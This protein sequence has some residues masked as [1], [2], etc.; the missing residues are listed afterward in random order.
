M[1]ITA[2]ITKV[3]P[4]G[5]MRAAA[6]VELDGRFVIHGVKLIV[7]ADKTF[8]SMPSRKYNDR[9][10]DICHPLDS[11]TRALMQEAVIAA[12]DELEPE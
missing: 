10:Y 5:N 1:Q 8:I 6:N 4:E 2:K 12:Y 7:L 9:F 11:E 3:F